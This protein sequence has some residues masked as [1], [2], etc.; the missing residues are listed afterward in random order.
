MNVSK[1]QDIFKSRGVRPALENGVPIL[2][3]GSER[4]DVLFIHAQTFVEKLAEKGLTI[5]EVTLEITKG[6]MVL[7]VTDPAPEPVPDEFEG[8]DYRKIVSMCKELE[9]PTKGRQPRAELI[10]LI[11]AKRLPP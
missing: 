10:E 2:V 1:L 5:D 3:R 8:I 6:E 11:K 4:K 7:T 9:I